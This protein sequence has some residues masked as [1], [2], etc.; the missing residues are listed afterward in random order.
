MNDL[1]N[2][3]DNRKLRN[4][5]DGTLH[6]KQ[7]FKTIAEMLPTDEHNKRRVTMDGIPKNQMNKYDGNKNWKMTTGERVE[8][9]NNGVHQQ[10][11]LV[12]EFHLIGKS[13]KVLK[14]EA[15]LCPMTTMSEKECFQ[16]N[17]QI[18]M[19]KAMVEAGRGDEVPDE[20]WWKSIRALEPPVPSPAN[21]KC[22]LCSNPCDCPFGNN[23]QPVKEGVCCDGCNVTKVIPARMARLGVRQ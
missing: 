17:T 14:T 16:V 1:N 21:P 18:E 13:G 23:A 8:I 22:V 19:A 4:T 15:H 10:T 2:P 12:V 7:P 11:M 9:M 6:T 3:S 20:E 5:L